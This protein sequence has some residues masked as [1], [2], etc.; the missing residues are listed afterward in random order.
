VSWPVPYRYVD[1]GCA[2]M[3]LLLAAVDEGLVAGFLGIHRVP[4]LR[5]LLGIPAGIRPVAWLCVGPVACLQEV[6][7]LERHG[8]RRRRPLQEAV[9]RERW[10]TKAVP[11]D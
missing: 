8:W 2:L 11:E 5:D 4:G 3:L 6:P 9:H 10:G 7:D 1:A